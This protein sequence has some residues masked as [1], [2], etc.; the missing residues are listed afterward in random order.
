MW[1]VS[2]RKK[3][4]KP[5]GYAAEFCPICRAPRIFKIF[6]VGMSTH[7]YYIPVGEGELTG[8]AGK[9]QQ[10]STKIPIDASKFVQF[11]KETPDKIDTLIQTTY[12]EFYTD[13]KARL[14]LES[15]PERR[16]PVIISDQEKL[17]MEPFDILSMDVE[18]RFAYTPVDRE[19]A[20]AI[21]A[22]SLIFMLLCCGSAAFIE[23]DFVRDV[24][25][26]VLGFVVIAGVVT[27]FVQIIRAP[28]RYIRRMIVPRLSQSLRPLNPARSEITDCIERIKSK[29][30]R[31]GK[32]IDEEHLWEAI[33]QR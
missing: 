17:L 2:G 26:L 6:R 22:T 21:A 27:T 5:L 11:E 24:I 7:I 25:N 28:K 4:E 10:C 18:E 20:I 8:Y 9:C 33:Q 3:V 29:G 19:I 15:R 31:L 30:L 14:E 13:Y 16:E 1:L 23:D 32:Y 12:P